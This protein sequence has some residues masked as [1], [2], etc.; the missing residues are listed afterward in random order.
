M[1]RRKIGLTFVGLAFIF[2]I[3]PAGLYI[4][5]IGW[6]NLKL[7]YELNKNERS[8]LQMET[9]GEYLTKATN[10]AEILK[11]KMKSLGWTFVGQ[12]GSGYFFEKKGQE[13][14]ITAKQIWNRHYVVY[15]VKD[16]IVDLSH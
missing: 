10:Q 9:E 14:I 12:E 4:N 11:E 5:N 15:K 13:S 1:K 8:I 16:N 2:L 7:I 6:N 3:I